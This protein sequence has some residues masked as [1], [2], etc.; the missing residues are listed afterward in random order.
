MR[1][2]QFLDGLLAGVII[3]TLFAPA[4]GSETRRRLAKK[5]AHFRDSLRNAQKNSI[6][7]VSDSISELKRAGEGRGK[8]IFHA[9]KQ[10]DSV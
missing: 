5:F 8:R 7:Q 2:Q 4:R 10:N 9:I 3:G 6:A 1:L